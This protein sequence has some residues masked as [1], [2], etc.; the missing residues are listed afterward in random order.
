MEP[1]FKNI[2]YGD[3]TLYERDGSTVFEVIKGGATVVGEKYLPFVGNGMGF[4][5]WLNKPA[6][7]E[8]E[9]VIIDT[10]R[11]GGK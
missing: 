7:D 1:R 3:L 4:L 11:R 6:A 2:A 8:G 10:S 5:K 9:I